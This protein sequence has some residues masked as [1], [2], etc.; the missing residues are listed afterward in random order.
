M[1][2]LV[3]ALFSVLV[4]SAL[5]QQGGAD[6][7]KPKRIESKT[8]PNLLQ[9]SRKVYS[10]GLPAGQRAFE[11]L[12]S[13]GV[14]TVISVDGAVPDVEAAEKA[15][16]RYIHLPHGYDGI[17]ESRVL[18]IAKA[19]SQSPGS[20]LIHCHRGKHRSPAASAVACTAIGEIEPDQATK[21][22]EAAGTG[23][24]Y[25]G[26]FAAAKNAKLLDPQLIRDLQVEFKSKTPAPPLVEAMGQLEVT[27]ERLELLEKDHFQ[28]VASQPDLEPAHQALLLREC[29]T[30]LLRQPELKSK[31]ES[32]QKMMQEAETSAKAVEEALV[33]WKTAKYG[34]SPPRGFAKQF[35]ALAQSCKKCHEAFRDNV[36]VQND[37]RCDWRK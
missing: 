30:E 19:I 10:G 16:L 1:S 25:L 3:A 18:E 6:D 12:K 31:P 5:W 28:S 37:T 29:Y 4:Q 20:V 8:V 15:G 14:T 7:W 13:L 24:N 34:G 27:L 9:I 36:P 21:V 26:L 2:L 32:F 33:G 17:S 22:L 23:K 35:G 11:E